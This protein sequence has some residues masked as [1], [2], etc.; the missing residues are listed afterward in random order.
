VCCLRG[1]INNNNNPSI[2]DG[3]TTAV[4]RI[5][6]QARRTVE[7]GDDAVHAV[8]S[9][10]LVLVAVHTIRLDLLDESIDVL[11]RRAVRRFAADALQEDRR[12]TDPSFALQQQQPTTASPAS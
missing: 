6:T 11:G 8:E 2:S 1:V 10:V 5:E 3:H 4:D 9:G 7:V 12:I